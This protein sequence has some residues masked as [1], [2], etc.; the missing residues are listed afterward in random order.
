MEF[1][2]NPARAAAD[3]IGGY[4]YQ[5][6]VTI[7]RWLDLQPSEFLELERGEDL[8]AI[9]VSD[10]HLDDLR[11]LQQVKATAATLTLRSK[12]ALT[13]IA[14][15]CEHRRLNP[16]YLLKFR[17]ITTSSIGRE[18]G[19]ALQGSAIEV[20][21]SVR[22]GELA[23]HDEANA[24]SAIREF[25][26]RCTKPDGV[27]TSTWNFLTDILANDNQSQFRELIQAFE[28]S[29]GHGN[30]ES[31]EKEI[32]RALIRS[33]FVSDE[34][35]AESVFQRL[36]LYVFK[37]L[38]E[39]GLKRLTQEEL[40]MQ[41]ASPALSAA[42]QSFVATIRL[43]SR[44]AAL[45]SARAQDTSILRSLNEQLQMIA[46]T[47]KAQFEYRAAQVSLDVPELAQ[48]T[49]HR[50]HT[51]NELA[52]QMAQKAW[53][54][55]IGEPGCG[56][57]Q[58]CLLL[59]DRLR[60]EPLWINLR[61]LTEDRACA[62]IDSSLET[63]SGVERYAIIQRWYSDA[64]SRLNPRTTV[65]LDD[66]PRI[67]VGGPLYHR[68]QFLQAACQA[69][70][71]RML[72]TTYFE[73]PRS[74]SENSIAGEVHAPL[75][76]T[77]EILDL[78]RANAAPANVANAKF[79][80]FLATS[81]RGLAVMV[82]AVIRFLSSKNWIF[83]PEVIDSLFKGEY[84]AGARHDAKQ[85]I[86]GTVTDSGARELLYRL[87]CTV[88]PISREQ[89]E[90]VSKVP[91][92]ITLSL[93]KFDQ[94][95][96]IWVQPYGPQ[97]YLLSPLVDVNWADLLDSNTRKGVHATLAFLELRKPLSMVDVMTCVHHFHSAEQDNPAIIVLLQALV[98][99]MDFPTE[100]SNEWMVSS[101]WAHQSLPETV[102]INL[103]LNLRAVQIALAEK[104]KKDYSFLSDD[105]KQLLSQAQSDGKAQLG[106]FMASSLLATQLFRKNPSLANHYILMALRSAREAVLPDGEKLVFPKEMSLEWILW[107]TAVAAKSDEEVQNWLDTVAQLSPAQITVLADSEF[108]EDNSTVICDSVCLRE[109]RKPENERNW[110]HVRQVISQIERRAAELGL[111]IL[112]AAAIR[113]K[114]I[115]LAECGDRLPE[116]LKLA[117]VAL[118][119]R[120]DDSGRFLIEEAIGRQLAYGGRWQEALWWMGLAL[121][122]H[123]KNSSLWR[124]NLLV[125]VAEG[126][127]RYDPSVAPEYARQA[128]DVAKSANLAPVRVAEAL[129]EYAISLWN[130]EEREKAFVELQ[131]A[132]PLIVPEVDQPPSDIQVFL[133]FLHAAAYF[134]TMAVFNKPPITNKREDYTAPAPGL[135]LATDR[136]PMELYQPTKNNHLLIQ[137]AMFAEG[138]GH[139]E[140]AGKWASLALDNAST[141]SAGD[142]LK[143]FIWLTIAPSLLS[144]EY[145]NALDRARSMAGT[146]VPSEQELEAIG[147]QP[148]DHP[149]IQQVFSNKQRFELS[150]IFGVV[151]L[152][153][154]LC[155]VRF[156]RDVSAD[157]EGIATHLGSIVGP[158]AS[159]WKEAATLLVLILSKNEQSWRQLHDRG[160]KYYR[161]NR[162]AFGILSLL[163][164]V[165]FSHEAR[166]LVTQ[167]KI[168]MDLERIFGAKPSIKYKILSPFFE[169]YWDKVIA[170]GSAAFR[171]AA[172]YTRR[173]FDEA[174]S[175]PVQ[176]RLRAVFRSMVFCIGLS[177]P[178]D[179]RDW[180]DQSPL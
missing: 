52:D 57:T 18:Q 38:T 84:A 79:A 29:T 70:G 168:A 1:V 103:R 7:S 23:G 99:V 20:W 143:P 8:D 122:R 121:Q 49:I 19:W 68:L 175:N 92:R 123:T 39:S 163:G 138:V 95:V 55:I 54:S 53:L 75:F 73:M 36:F 149:R 86:E 133:A 22:A 61:G 128:V 82:A 146:T 171:T 152:A 104:R 114:I 35:H 3:A 76:T 11:T 28:W 129:G 159:D 125:T 167:I 170:N 147:I 155:T 63:D 6:Y 43:E 137:I 142:L 4:V 174:R 131:E 71:H 56:K 59:I 141:V 108:A 97:A 24:V 154:R 132:V 135:F 110:D 9:R 48:P 91:S 109:Y 107:G 96:G 31:L 26:Q 37:K 89:V 172:A 51:V 16:G 74:L 88:G 127:A 67:V 158:G 176:T 64:V 42:D 136:I 162:I 169:H 148:G 173:S 94:L 69:S 66:V 140:A 118:Q 27:K 90:M 81:T 5:V 80:A 106:V 113:A 166:S 100:V 130:A 93:E 180:L 65:V 134:G 47:A 179:L 33:A 87:T 85:I 139:T 40:R 116:A 14:N 151:P 10:N 32:K 41:L 160:N 165:L 2:S 111:D 150:L 21:E 30:A 77:E 156:E 44:V 15:F 13:A 46:G 161:E 115:T 178:N 112:N 60:S 144:G 120:S 145:I 157:I 101:L 153:F 98:K 119:T 83:Q 34:E 126:I 177:L 124:R 72:S 102:D 17:Y 25:L 58:L 117:E 62:V 164:S 12:N 78:L 50:E 105:L 45:E